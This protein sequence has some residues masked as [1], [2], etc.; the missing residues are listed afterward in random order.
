VKISLII[1][2]AC[3][4]ERAWQQHGGGGLY[5]ATMYER[6][7]MLR[8]KI[9]PAAIQQ[10]I[11]EI[12]V[13]GR[14]MRIDR[15]EAFRQREVGAR[16]STGEILVCTADDH[17]LSDTFAADLRGVLTE[18]WDILTPK[19]L[20]GVTGETLNN[21]Q[22]EGYSPWHCQVYRRWV[23]AMLPF[24]AY[25]TLWVDTVLPRMYE[26]IDAKLVWDDRLV[27]VDVEAKEGER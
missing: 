14:P 10:E 17:M 8:D 19:R 11:D 18:D 15:I 13:V 5:S 2:T 16:F 25:D 24:T 3:G 26:E 27:C 20:H 4:D 12:W 23:W 9:L 1:T 21:G 22:E 6:Q 7:A